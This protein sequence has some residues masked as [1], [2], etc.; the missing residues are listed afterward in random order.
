MTTISRKEFDDQLSAGGGWIDP[1]DLSPELQR[2]LDSAGIDRARLAAIAGKDGVISGRAEADELFALVDSFDDDRSARSLNPG[3]ADHPTASGELYRALRAE[4]DRRAAGAR[5]AGTDGAGARELNVGRM[6]DRDLVGEAEAVRGRLATGRYPLRAADEAWLGTL[7][8]EI[9]RRAAARSPV[10]DPQAMGDGSSWPERQVGQPMSR[11]AIY[12]YALAHGERQLSHALQDELQ[13]PEAVGIWSD[14]EQETPSDHAKRVRRELVERGLDALTANPFGAVFYGVASGLTDDPETR[15]AAAELGA[16]LG[17]D[18]IAAEAMRPG[19]VVVVREPELVPLG[20]SDAT[21]NRNARASTAPTHIYLIQRTDL[22]TGR[23]EVFKYGVGSEEDLAGESTRAKRQ[24]RNL[25]R[26]SDGTTV[27]SAVIID[28]TPPNRG[29]AYDLERDYVTEY[30]LAHPQ[31]GKPAGN[32]LPNAWA[33]G[34]AY[35]D[36]A[37]PEQK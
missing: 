15:I 4:I 14:G 35:E 29:E 19:E 37:W 31:E 21:L 32:A 13:P 30:V 27:Y 9:G 6:S 1:D 25:N 36:R 18:V 10:R 26:D 23:T 7:D 12:Q 20:G 16:N 8:R 34:E 11:L 24:V 28:R 22:A 5:L 33:D 2:E 3:T 17:N